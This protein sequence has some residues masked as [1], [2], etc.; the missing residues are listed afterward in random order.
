[1]SR[2]TDEFASLGKPRFIV[3]RYWPG[4]GLDKNLSWNRVGD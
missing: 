1:M 2:A 4:V 3:C